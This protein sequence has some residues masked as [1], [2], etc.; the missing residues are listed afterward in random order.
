MKPL[1][2]SEICLP[3]AK[4]SIKKQEYFVRYMIVNAEES[5]NLNVALQKDGRVITKRRC[6]QCQSFQE[7]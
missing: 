6:E 2:D 5:L 7:N 4:Q 1:W 3:E